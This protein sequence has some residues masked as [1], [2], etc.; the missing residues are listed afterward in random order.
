MGPALLDTAATMTPTESIHTLVPRLELNGS[1]WA[2]FSVRFKGVM[3]ATDRWGHFNGTELR[4]VAQDPAAPTK[5]KLDAQTHWDRE[6]RIGRN[7]LLQR[8]PDSTVMRLNSLSTAHE[9]WD[10]LTED[11]KAKNAYAKSDLQEA[12]FDMRCPKNGDVRAFLDRL[13]LKREELAAAGAPVTD[14]DYERAILCGIP[15]DFA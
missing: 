13:S 2:A 4:P 11:Y 9:R 12:F 10:R 1:N 3:E 5:D 6:D 15:E 14:K 7:F 8:L